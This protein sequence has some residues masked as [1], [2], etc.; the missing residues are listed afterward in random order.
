LRIVTWSPDRSSTFPT[1]VA[2][3]RIIGPNTA[4]IGPPDAV[5]RDVDLVGA[6]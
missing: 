5:R 3:D 1:D 4:T 2:S 6:R